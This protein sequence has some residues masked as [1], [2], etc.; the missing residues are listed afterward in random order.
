MVKQICVSEIYS[1]ED[2]NTLNG[3]HFGDE[4]I[5]ELFDEDIDIFDDKGNF[6]LSFRKNILKNTKIG[7]DNYKKFIYASRGRGASAG[8]ID[9]EQKYWKKRKLINTKGFSTGYLKEDGTPSNMKVNNHVYSSPIGYFDKLNGPLG[10]KLP[11]RLTSYTKDHYENYVEGLPF[12]QEIAEYYQKI[13]PVEFNTQDCRASLKPEFKIPETPFS[14]ITINRNFRTAL[15]KDKG[16]FGGVACLSVLEEGQ[17]NGGL[18]M[19]PRYGIGINLRQGDLLIADVHQ[20]HCN[21]ELWTTPEQDKHNQDSCPSFQHVN[22]EVGTIGSEYDF[23]RISF[24]CYLR[25]KIINC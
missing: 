3:K 14:T 16:D 13:R 1:E 2:L 5:H 9:P 15:H 18:F 12:I 20:Y 25:E 4:W 7:F 23:S 24:V 19:I 8:P 17:F 6:I 10:K 11:C 22:K 21:T